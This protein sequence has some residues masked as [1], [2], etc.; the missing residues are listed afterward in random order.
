METDLTFEEF[1]D[2]V[3]E[4]KT[5]YDYKNKAWIKGGRVVN[6]GHPNSMNCQCYQRAHAGEIHIC[7]NQCH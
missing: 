3:N 4:G 2:N 1:V 6:C 5:H 7:N